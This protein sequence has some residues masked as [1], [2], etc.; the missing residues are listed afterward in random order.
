MQQE[1]RMT[2]LHSY[3]ENQI[4]VKTPNGIT[5]REKFKE[6]VMQGDVLAPLMS[7]LQVD[8][9]GKEC[10]EQEKH[11]Y[12]FED[13]V[14]VPPLGLVDDLFTISVCGHKTNMMNQPM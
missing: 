13:T 2:Y 4:S 1:L 3:M 10:F 7:S 6:I 8:T 12:Y 11:L 5:R 9:I 14:P